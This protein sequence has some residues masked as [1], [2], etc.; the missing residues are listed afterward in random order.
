MV[1]D[2]ITAHRNFEAAYLELTE[3]AKNPSTA[4]RM[5][6]EVFPKIKSAVNNWAVNRAIF[7]ELDYYEEEGEVLG[8]H[9]KL[10]KLKI[11]RDV[12]ALGDL[13]VVRRLHTVRANVSRDR[14]KLKK[15]KGSAKEK[16]EH[17]FNRLRLEKELLEQRYKNNG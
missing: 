2:K 8:K 3:A 12:R 10:W 16:F 15:L 7:E 6:D 14:K 5:T 9:P 17:T 13:Q 1:S 4:L 11:E